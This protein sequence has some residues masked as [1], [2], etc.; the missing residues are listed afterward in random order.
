MQEQLL[1]AHKHRETGKVFCKG[2]VKRSG[3]GAPVI[4]WVETAGSWFKRIAA[5]GPLDPSAALR[6]HLPL[7]GKELVRSNVINRW[8]VIYISDV[9]FGGRGDN[10]R[11]RHS[12][13]FLYF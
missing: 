1:H 11:V 13:D 6:A 12:N 5:L 7:A 3:F 8:F 9:I 10:F 2:I 4:R